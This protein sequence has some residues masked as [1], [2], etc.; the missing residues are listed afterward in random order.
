MSRFFIRRIFAQP[1][2][3][4]VVLPCQQCE[5]LGMPLKQNVYI[6]TRTALQQ[7]VSTWRGIEIPFQPVV[8]FAAQ[9]QACYAADVRSASQP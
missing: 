7:V 2:G 8:A 4:A 5:T 9:L 3:L 1:G 6:V